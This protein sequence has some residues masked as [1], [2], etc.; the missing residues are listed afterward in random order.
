MHRMLPRVDAMLFSTSNMSCK[1]ALSTGYD[2][3]TGLRRFVVLNTSL[4][5]LY[6]CVQGGLRRFAVASNGWQTF[7]VF[8]NRYKYH[9]ESQ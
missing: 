8:Q 6:T 3:H 4:S 5:T 9:T 2:K 1:S 7:I